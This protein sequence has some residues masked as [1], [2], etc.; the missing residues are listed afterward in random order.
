MGYSDGLLGAIVTLALPLLAFGCAGQPQSART[1]AGPAPAVGDFVQL[2][3]DLLYAAKT[4]DSTTA[5]SLAGVL[6][7]ASADA[8]AA[9]LEEPSRNKAFWINLYNAYAY[10]ITAGKQ[11]LKASVRHRLFSQARITIAG[12]QLS[13]N[14]IEHGILRRSKIWWSMGYLNKLFPGRFERRFRV[15]EL[16]PRLHFALNCGASSCPPIAFYRPGRLDA[17]LTQAT[18][19]YLETSTA[20]KPEANQV[21]VSSLFRW[22]RADFGGRSGTLAMLRAYSI[23]PEGA[24]PKLVYKSWDWTPD[25]DNFRDAPAETAQQE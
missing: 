5:D 4:R 22:Y 9:D 24:A 12:R 14:K 16:D 7:H 21:Q 15:Q 10:R 6:A 13:L 20:Y 1:A 17:Q 25:R 23:I 11:L 2:S 3:Q 19:S 8:M 18:E